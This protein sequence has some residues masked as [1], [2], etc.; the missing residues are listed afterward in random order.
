MPLNGDKISNRVVRVAGGIAVDVDNGDES[1][2][3]I[4]NILNIRSL[5]GDVPE[6]RYDE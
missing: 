2:D 4:V 3:R 6:G 5:R 1:A